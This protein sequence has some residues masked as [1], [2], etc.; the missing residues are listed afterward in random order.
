MLSDVDSDQIETPT[1]R[2]KCSK[3]HEKHHISGELVERE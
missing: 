1:L 3:S 2:D